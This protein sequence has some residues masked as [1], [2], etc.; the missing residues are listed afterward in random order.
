MT[1]PVPLPGLT[2]EE[3]S[4]QVEK[5]PSLKGQWPFRPFEKRHIQLMRHF[6]RP[7]CDGWFRSCVSCHWIY[8]WPQ[9]AVPPG[10]NPLRRGCVYRSA[11]EVPLLGE[12]R[13]GPWHFW[14]CRARVG[15]GSAPRTTLRKALCHTRPVVG[16]EDK[17]HLAHVY[18]HSNI[19]RV[20]QSAPIQALLRKERESAHRAAWAIATIH[21]R[22]L[23]SSSYVHFLFPAWIL[24]VRLAD[25]KIPW[26]GRDGDKHWWKILL[27]IITLN[28]THMLWEI[29]NH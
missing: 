8:L 2:G 24:L 3:D 23:F 25:Y 27:R 7:W 11:P 29:D 20:A 12:C 28:F 19:W 18:D 1:K 17:Y 14:K 22:W 6:G 13:R 4:Y 10:F 5:K 15:F 26:P 9:V 21:K 16:T